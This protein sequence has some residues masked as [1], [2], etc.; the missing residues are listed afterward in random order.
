MLILDFNGD[1]DEDD[2][3]LRPSLED[4]EEVKLDPEEPIAERIKLNP[5]KRK[6]TETG[7]NI[8]T[9]NKLLTRFSILL[10][11]IKARNNSYNL[12]NEIRQILYFCISIMKS[13]TNLQQFH[14]VTIIMEENMI[15]MRDPKTF[16]LILIGSKM[17]VRIWNM[18]L[19]LSQKV[20]NL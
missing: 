19:N 14:Q 17:L 3:P 16:V 15:V 4:D 18:K 20:M 11:Q 1:E 7:L 12:K 6:T 5:R 9:H 8:L 13:L 2:L 10:A